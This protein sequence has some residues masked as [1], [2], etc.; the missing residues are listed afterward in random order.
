MEVSMI[1][2]QQLFSLQAFTILDEFSPP[3][4]ICLLERFVDLKKGDVVIQNG[5]NSA[6]GK[7]LF[8]SAMSALCSFK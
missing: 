4:A 3:T 1:S 2:I 7:V 5:A 8:A 6:V